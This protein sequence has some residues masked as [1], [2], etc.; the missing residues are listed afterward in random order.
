MSARPQLPNHAPRAKVAPTALDGLLV[1]DFTRVVAGPACTQIL[2]DFGAE[3]IKIENPDGGDDTRSYEHADL[4]GES[5]AFVSLNRNK[6]GIALDLTKPEARD[7]ALELIAR[8][9]VVVENFSAGVM[10]KYGLDYASVAPTNPRLVYCSISAYGRQG[11]FASRPGFDPIT[12]AE[13][14]FMSLNGFADGPPVRTGPPAI[15]MVTGISAC[16]AIMM[17]LFARDRLGRGQQV[18]VALFDIALAMTQFYGMAYLMT[19]VNPSRQGNSPNGSPSVGVYDASDAP[20]Y[21]A[22]ANDR[23]YRRLVIEVLGRPDLASGEFVDRRSRSANKK[24]LRAILT[25]IF[26]Q[27][28][29]ENWVTKMKAANIPVGYLRT[30]EEAFNSPEVRQRHRLSQIPHPA[31]GTVPNIES[32]LHLGLTP[33]IDP[34][35]APLLG[36]HTKEVLRKTLGYDDARI[37]ALAEAGVFGTVS[38]RG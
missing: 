4:A 35:A 17:A 22:C 34:V 33:V 14:G 38:G 37:A 15:D 9:D 32:P 7:V 16:N 21:I 25:E 19:G 30:V 26:A 27:D 36:E 24:K 13:S 29:R 10:K 6:R 18:E 12:Q 8:A 31:A 3:V 2:A 11:P 28:L 23:L 1:V 5:A 20:F